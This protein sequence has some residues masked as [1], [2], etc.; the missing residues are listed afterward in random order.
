MFFYA[1]FTLGIFYFYRTLVITRGNVDDRKPVSNLLRQVKG[2][3]FADKGYVSQPLFKALLQKGTHLISSVRSNMKNKLMPVLDRVLL[4][5]RFIIETINDQ[6]KNISQ[7]EH[8][9]HRSP[10][11]FL[12][13]IVA[14]LSAYQAQ[15]KK[16]SLRIH[17]NKLALAF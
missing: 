16:P 11:N 14:A 7:L 6:L 5:K 1:Y 2:K 3:V 4:R 13:N 12:V 8:T 17:P 10:I 9:R 15:E